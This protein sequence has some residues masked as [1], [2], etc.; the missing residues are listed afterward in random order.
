MSLISRYA[1]PEQ[2]IICNHVLVETPEDAKFQMHIHDVCEMIYLVSGNISAI[3][4]EKT[5]KLPKNSVVF[6]RANVPHRIRIDASDEPYERYNIIF[7]ENLL[8]N[9]IFF[10]IP[11][12][13]DV[14]DYTGEGRITDLLKKLDY[15]PQYFDGDN[16]Q[17]LITGIVEELLFNL[18][19]M[20]EDTIDEALLAVHPLIGRAVTY[21]NA[22]YAEPI[23]VDDICKQLN[24][25]KSYLHRLFIDEMGISPKK[26]VNV[27]RLAKAQRLIR[28]GKRPSHIYEECGFLEY[29]TFFRN[30]SEYFGYSPS[31]ENKI[32]I[33]RKIES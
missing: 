10:E 28:R 15:Y 33:E 16:L 23:T 17:S 1:N 3:I 27:R 8:A 11:H 5:Y 29:A 6:F 13:I 22:H 24:I 31:Q 30:Y 4:G 32:E 2:S 25:T 7:D 19:L 20:P 9:R 18:Y 12:G 21:I 14:I 26:Y